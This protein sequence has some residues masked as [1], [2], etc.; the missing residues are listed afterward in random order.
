MPGVNF[1]RFVQIGS[2]QQGRPN[3]T[4]QITQ[5]DGPL[6]GVAI[7]GGVALALGDVCMMYSVALLGLAVGPAAINAFSIVLGASAA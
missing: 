5:P 7:F 2:P 6:A 1:L 3:F 4:T